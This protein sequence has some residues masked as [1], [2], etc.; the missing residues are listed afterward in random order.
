MR[1][2]TFHYKLNSH[3]MGYE[4]YLKILVESSL[5]PQ[6]EVLNMIV[7]M[8]AETGINEK[9]FIPIRKREFKRNKDKQVYIVDN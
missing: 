6:K 9:E 5:E 4:A 7:I 2:Y 8:A 1:Q 3:I